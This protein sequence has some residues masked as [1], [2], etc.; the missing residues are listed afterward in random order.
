M[1]IKLK[2]APSVCVYISKDACLATTVEE[3]GK[4]K[5]ELPEAWLEHWHEWMVG[6]M[7]SG[8]GGQGRTQWM[9]RLWRL[10]C[11]LL[12]PK[13][14]PPRPNGQ[15]IPDPTSCFRDSIYY[16]YFM[17]PSWN[18][19][20]IPNA[21]QC[22]SFLPGH[23]D[24]YFWRFFIVRKFHNYS[25]IAIC[26]LLVRSCFLITLS[27]CLKYTSTMVPNHSIIGPKK[28]IENHR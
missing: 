12:L 22:H 25:M 28:P 26:F 21:V 23:H 6:W 18:I 24:C 3:D 15:P 4:G 17:R 27:K 14:L 13:L 19:E 1:R 8:G 20:G 7:G 16:F 9:A 10:R 5:L 11:P 2:F